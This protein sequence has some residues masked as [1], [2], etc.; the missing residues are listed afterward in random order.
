MAAAPE[1]IAPVVPLRPS[2][3]A[4]PPAP[5]P[6]RRRRRLAPRHDSRP[7]IVVDRRVP[8]VH[9][10]N[11][12]SVVLDT[13]RTPAPPA[14][15]VGEL[16]ALRQAGHLA[17]AA[18]FASS[19]KEAAAILRQ[20]GRMGPPVPPST[21]EKLLASRDR[22]ESVEPGRLLL[23]GGL[24]ARVMWVGAMR[25]VVSELPP[26]MREACVPARV[27]LH[28]NL[29]GRS[30]LALLAIESDPE[31]LDETTE[32]V[33]AGARECGVELRPCWGSQLE[34]WRYSLP[35]IAASE[36]SR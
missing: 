16:V 6:L 7:S 8:L 3:S 15:R 27:S 33:V 20:A 18:C 19:A 1:H 17:C 28:F 32:R 25:C 26:T 11:I 22:P 21:L 30:R 4:P 31:D 34:A 14:Q 23:K 29:L 12:W 13:R 5:V 10:G 9:D 24:A 2:A 35:L 36:V